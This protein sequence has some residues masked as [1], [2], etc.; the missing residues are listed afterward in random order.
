MDTQASHHYD[1][2]GHYGGEYG[3]HDGGKY[4]KGAELSSLAH[5]SALQ[6]KNA[7]HNQHTAGSQAAYGVKSSLASA[8]LGV[9]VKLVYLVLEAIALF[10]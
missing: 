3:G 5:S 4:N 7:V 9:S 6:A 8:A 2:Y 1:S 10:Q